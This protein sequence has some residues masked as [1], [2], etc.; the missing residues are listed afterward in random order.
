MSNSIFKMPDRPRNVAESKDWIRQA[1]E[2]EDAIEGWKEFAFFLLMLSGLV[3]I[4][5]S[6]ARLFV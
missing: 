2:R 3:F 5:W 1:K 4:I 6:I